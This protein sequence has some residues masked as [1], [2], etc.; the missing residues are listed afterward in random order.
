MA[1]YELWDTDSR[2]LI[3]DYDREEDALAVV[4]LNVSEHGPSVLEGVALSVARASQRS[5]PK[6]KTSSNGS[7]DLDLMPARAEGQHRDEFLEAW[8][9]FFLGRRRARRERRRDLRARQLPQGD[10]PEVAAAPAGA[11][12]ASQAS[13]GSGSATPIMASRVTSRA[14]CASEKSSVPGGRG[15]MTR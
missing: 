3:G 14:S 13:V 12:A 7:R 15:G 2:S 4:R 8:R 11:A 1:H 5:S 10:A 9:K 6:G